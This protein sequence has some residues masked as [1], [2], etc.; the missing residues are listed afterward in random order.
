[1]IDDFAQTAN[2]S[3]VT[4]FGSVAATGA[5]NTSITGTNGTGYL[6]E[7]PFDDTPAPDI[8]TL[9]YSFTNG[10]S[11]LFEANMSHNSI[12]IAELF[13]PVFSSNAYTLRVSM[14]DGN[15]ETFLH[16]SAGAGSSVLGTSTTPLVVSTGRRIIDFTGADDVSELRFQFEYVGGNNPIDTARL[17]FGN[18]AG[19][20]VATPEPASAVMFGTAALGM[21]VRRRRKA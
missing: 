14:I 9:S 7:T 19:S 11:S 13:V 12:E 4:T 3:L 15:G 2:P 8:A 10:F 21:F 6:V 20:L 16:G 1:V 17:R 5:G 18:S